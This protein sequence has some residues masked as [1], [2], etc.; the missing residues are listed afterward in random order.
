MMLLDLPPE[1]E[2]SLK[3]QA[4]ARGMTVEQWFLQLA[5]QAGPAAWDMKTTQDSPDL[6]WE[7]DFEEWLNGI[8]ETPPLSDEAIS[9]ASLYPDR[10]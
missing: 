2:N 5:E 1:K 7:A 4:Q 6:S 10:W 3:A 9:R 8:P